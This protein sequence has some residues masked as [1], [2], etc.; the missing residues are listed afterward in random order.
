M[1]SNVQIVVGVYLLVANLRLHFL[2]QSPDSLGRPSIHSRERA[3][4][5][6]FQ[7]FDEAQVIPPADLFGVGIGGPRIQ[8]QP[9]DGLFNLDESL[10]FEE[11]PG[12]VLVR[13]RS[14]GPSRRVVEPVVPLPNVVVR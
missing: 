9:D 6:G 7:S 11:L 10:R 14:A 3:E 12:V 2:Y 1:N 4:T 5:E 13:D 8:R